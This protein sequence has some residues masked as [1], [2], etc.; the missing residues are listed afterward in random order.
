MKAIFKS[1]MALMAIC[2]FTACSDVPMPYSD[3]TSDDN[4]NGGETT[5]VYL[6][7]S[8]ASDFGKF[9]AYTVKGT[10]WVIDYST[11]KATGYDN[12]AQK[13]TES[14]AY[15]ISTAVDLS[16]STG[17][18]LQF[19]Y[20]LRYV[21]T[22]KNQN[23]VLI[24]DAYSGDPTTTNWTDI[25]GTLTEGS[26]WTTFSTYKKN[27]PTNFIGKSSVVVALMYSC[28]TSS[29]T[30]EMKNLVMKEGQVEESGDTPVEN[31][32]LNTPETAWTVAEA[33]QKIND[34]GGNALS[35]QAYVKGIIS[36]VDNYSEDYHSLTYYISDDGTDTN[37]L[38]VYSGKGIDG[39]DFASK[40]DLKKGQTVVVKGKL[41]A[42]NGK[43]EMDKNNTLISVSGEGEEEPAA[44]GLNATFESS[45]EGFTIKNI[46]LSDGLTDVWVY[47]S[48]NKCMKANGYN[49]D[50]KTNC[51]A[52]SMIV[53]PAFSL[54]GLNTARLTYDQAA[55]YMN[56]AADELQVLASTDGTNWTRLTPSGYPDG[57]SWTFLS[58]TC[59]MRAFAGQKTVYVAFQYTSTSESAPEWRLKNVVVK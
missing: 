37:T 30:I 47:D 2:A 42:Y 54:E 18:Y 4:D 3:P 39:A 32:D 33:I 38:Q 19:D 5:G 56:N 24:T 43:A 59:D 27:I 23:K 9:S 8:F 6:D 55:K 31:T 17:A 16:K 40:S 35:G 21:N 14:E 44:T 41:Q 28:T 53:S 7:E 22:A 57:S 50:K 46:S 52:Q 1:V 29:S 10:P 11:A 15:L 13:T 26:D 51:P 48:N 25:T 12:S 34:N 20:I 49:K 58:T 36:S 45:D